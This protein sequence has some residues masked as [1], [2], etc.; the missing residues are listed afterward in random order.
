MNRT[1]WGGRVNYERKSRLYFSKPE[2]WNEA[3][4][5]RLPNAAEHIQGATIT[6]GDYSRL[7]EEPGDDVWVYCDPP[8]YKPD[9]KSTSLLYR[10]NFE[11]N[12]DHE[13]FAKCFL[14]SPHK[15]CV[16]YEDGDYVRE[17]FS[18]RNAHTGFETQFHTEEWVYGG[19]SQETKRV[20]KELLILNYD[21]LQG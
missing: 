2:G 17:T 20:G 7:L 12:E 4:L 5:E 1:V 15:V 14:N 10:H 19:T 13:R 21:P 11:K 9:L 16:S 18:G 8:Y 6:C 3:T